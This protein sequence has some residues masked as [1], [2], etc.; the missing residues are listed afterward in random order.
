MKLSK[1]LAAA[2]RKFLREKAHR[3]EIKLAEHRKRATRKAM[4]DELARDVFAK[5]A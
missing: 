3:D 4:K 2:K 5:V 1:V